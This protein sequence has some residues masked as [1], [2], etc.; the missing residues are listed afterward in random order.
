MIQEL[1]GFI[2]LVHRRI[3]NDRNI[4]EADPSEGMDDSK[5]D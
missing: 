3:T 2:Q 5:R 4:D 1:I